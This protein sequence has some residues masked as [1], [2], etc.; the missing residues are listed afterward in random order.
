MIQIFKE[1]IKYI[2]LRIIGLTDIFTIL[3][4]LILFIIGILSVASA[5]GFARGHYGNT[6]TQ[7]FSF[8]LSILALIATLFF[9]YNICKK[10]PIILFAL[11]IIP[12]LIMIVIPSAGHTAYGA[13]RWLKIGP[14]KLQFSEFAKILF[15]LS[16]GA[17][18]DKIQENDPDKVNNPL[19]LLLLILHALIPIALIMKQPD[20]GTALVF[21]TITVC[22]LFIA[23]IN[24]K[25]VFSAMTFLLIMIP[26]FYFN[27]LPKLP[28]YIQNR[29]F[30]FLNPSSD[31]M[32][33]GYNVTMATRAIGSGEIF[34]EG[35]FKGSIVQAGTLPVAQ[36][37]FIFSVIGQELGFIGCI[38]V[39]CLYTFLIIRMISFL[40]KAKDSYGALIITGVTAMIIHH[41]IQNVGMNLALLPVAGIP[42]PFISYGGSALVSSMIGIGL[43]FSAGMYHHLIK[44]T[45]FIK[46][47][48]KDIN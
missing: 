10:H 43:I 19:N 35:L 4:V 37:D 32:G 8:G 41:V 22:M 17:H 44:D 16:F 46:N 1:K 31:P 39:L 47:K 48:T 7:L 45:I 21:C 24:K 20:N 15:I 26:T 30:V 3:T 23:G 6:I 38:A 40:K 5:T 11:L 25:Y 42:L 36:S 12:L 29:F 18:I 13:T 27:I 14:I 33:A 28:K 34:G 9:D 2:F